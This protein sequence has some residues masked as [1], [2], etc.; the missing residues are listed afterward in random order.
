MSY[1]DLGILLKEVQPAIGGVVFEPWRSDFEI[2]QLRGVVNFFDDRFEHPPLINLAE[3]CKSAYLADGS[4]FSQLHQAEDWHDGRCSG[5]IIW[6]R[7]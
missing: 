2:V 5:A 4:I 1:V 6:M 7:K 3:V